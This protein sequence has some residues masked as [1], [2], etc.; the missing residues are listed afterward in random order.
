MD[1]RS[2]TFNILGTLTRRKEGYHQ[3]LLENQDQPSEG[4]GSTV[5]AKTIHEIFDSK[6]KDLDQYLHFDGY[7]R[8]SFLDHFVGDSV[9]L[10]SFRKCVYQEEGDFIQEPYRIEA[11][12]RG[13]H[14]EVLFFRSGCLRKNGGKDSVEIEK[15]FSISGREKV[16]R[17]LYQV[18]YK[19]ERRRTNFGVEFNINLLA[20]DAPDRYYEI[21]EHSLEDRKLASVGALNDVTEVHLIN[22]WDRMKVTLRTDKSCHLWRFP[23]ETVSL[24]ESGF[25]KIFQ[26]SCLLLHWPLELEPGGH[27]EVTV[28]L[29][30]EHLP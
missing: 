30:I 29:G 4:E 8:A 19:G 9:D 26:G 10:E 25:E 3:K 17:A 24:S 6:E 28:E 20:G 23:I 18:T 16:V 5:R 7:R 2:K 15:R 13:K 12:R 27:F 11:R 22:E 1:D 21:P 14:Q